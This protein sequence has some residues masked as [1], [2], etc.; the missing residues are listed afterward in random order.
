MDRFKAKAF[1]PVIE[2]KSVAEKQWTEDEKSPYGAPPSIAL[3][4][5]MS[6]IF[7]LKLT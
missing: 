7:F 2:L 1:K 5:F 6:F 4:L 3:M